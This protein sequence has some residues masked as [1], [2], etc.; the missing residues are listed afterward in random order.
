MCG[1]VGG[2]RFGT[3]FTQSST[4]S[5]LFIITKIMEYSETRGSDATGIASLFDDGNFLI[6]K[7]GIGSKEFVSRTGGKPDDYEGLM[8]VLRGYSKADLRCVLGHCR[9]KSAGGSNNED[10]H[11]IKAGNIIGVHNGTLNNDDEIF[12][13]LKSQR[14]GKVDSEAIFRLLQFYTNDCKD[15]FTLDS[16]EETC[17]RLNGTFSFI[18]INANNPNQTV[19]A[20]DGRPAEFCLIKSLNLVLVASEKKFIETAL[21]NY[22]QMARLFPTGNEDTEFKVINKDEVEFGVLKN[23]HIAVFDLTNEITK[24]TELDNLFETRRIPAVREWKGESSHSYGSYGYYGSYKKNTT[25]NT[26]GAATTSKSTSSKTEDKEG[27]LWR[28]ELNKEISYFYGNKEL[29]RGGVLLDLKAQKTRDVD[30]F[31]KNEN[32]ENDMRKEEISEEVE[33][34]KNTKKPAFRNC[35]PVVNKDGVDKLKEGIEKGKKMA[36]KEIKSREAV[37]SAAKNLEKF[38]DEYE[39]ADFLE[40]E[41]DDLEELTVTALANRMI[42]RLFSNFFTQGWECCYDSESKEGYKTKATEHIRVLKEF[43]KG[44]IAELDVEKQAERVLANTAKSL[45]KEGKASKDDLTAIFSVGDLSKFE[46]LKKAI[47]SL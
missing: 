13:N 17:K 29:V 35:S 24:D 8:A 38:K 42:K 21:W 41:I 15:P 37:I 11:P 47:T 36:S 2:L 22:N 46:P 6:Q 10:N 27:H 4:V 30:F 34:F 28:K 7:M 1:I 19:V 20:R 12:S 18:A 26:R 45:A 33:D 39:V 44:M 25:M 3:E 32:A 43:S 23:D 16:A 31:C 14:D 5:M 9:K 40:I